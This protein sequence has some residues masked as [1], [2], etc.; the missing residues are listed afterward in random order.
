MALLHQTEP[1][2]V[3][4]GVYVDDLLASHPELRPIIDELD[5]DED[6]VMQK[7]VLVV[8]ARS[9]QELRSKMH[10]LTSHP[11]AMPHVFA[12][13]RTSKERL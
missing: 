10:S 8:F 3:M 2:R 4:A 7:D 1:A 5:K 13:E 11:E 12:F 9:W 6:A